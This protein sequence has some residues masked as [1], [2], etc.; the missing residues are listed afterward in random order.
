MRLPVS[1]NGRLA[2]GPSEAP[3]VE[4]EVDRELAP[5]GA[6][7]DRKGCEAASGSGSDP[8]PRL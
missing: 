6:S 2:Y 5:E 1:G 4:A 8:Y 3:A 7:C